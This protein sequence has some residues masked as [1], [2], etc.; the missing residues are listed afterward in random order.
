MNRIICGFDPPSIKN[1]GY[2]LFKLNDKQNTIS[3]LEAGLIKLEDKYDDELFDYDFAVKTSKLEDFINI[4][5]DERKID[6]II[7]EE[8]VLGKKGNRFM[9]PFLIAQTNNM[10]TTLQR[11]AYRNKIDRKLIHNKTLKKAI[12]GSGNASKDDVVEAIIGMLDLNI[13]YG[14]RTEKQYI[15]LYEHVF[16][17]MMLPIASYM[18]IGSYEIKQY[19]KKFNIEV[20]NVG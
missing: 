5:Y 20:I 9:S 17:A 10:S 7:I 15:K 19:E 3:L 2:A 13:N 14:D 4:F 8:Q 12:T 18:G 1:L 6:E 11:I 16:D